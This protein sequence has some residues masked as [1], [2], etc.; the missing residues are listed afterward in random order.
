LDISEKERSIIT[1]MHQLTKR[2]EQIL[3]MYFGL[4]EQTKT[5]IEEIGEIYDMTSEEVIEMKDEGIREFIRL[6][7][8]TGILGDRQKDFS[9]KF[10]Q[11]ND[12]E[13]LDNFMTKFIGSN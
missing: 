6:I 13:F 3:I 4:G 5:S 2:Q 11:S 10:I 9:D 1:L 12:S 7:A 8:S